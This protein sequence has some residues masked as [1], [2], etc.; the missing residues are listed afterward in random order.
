[1]ALQLLFLHFWHLCAIHLQIFDTLQVRKLKTFS[2][3]G[4]S[5]FYRRKI[6]IKIGVFTLQEHWPN[7]LIL[8]FFSVVY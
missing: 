1:V 8:Y 5:S 4:T 2:N 3:R 6:Q 7:A